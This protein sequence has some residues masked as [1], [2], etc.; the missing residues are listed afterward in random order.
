LSRKLT[1]QPPTLNVTDPTE[2]PDCIKQSTRRSGTS[3]LT[4]LANQIERERGVTA[5]MFA[6]SLRQSKDIEDL[7]VSGKSV[8]RSEAAS[9]LNFK[10][11]EEGKRLWLGF[12]KGDE[13]QAVTL[14]QDGKGLQ[15]FKSV[16]TT[17]ART[18]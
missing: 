6:K 14:T 9:C 18:I 4:Q 8:L 7:N 3:M 17:C 10:P 13:Q 2:V 11:H 15:N 5:T 16:Y 1:K 12:F